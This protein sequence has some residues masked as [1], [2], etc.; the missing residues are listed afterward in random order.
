MSL[1]FRPILRPGVNDTSFRR[2]VR[3]KSEDCLTGNT[4]QPVLIPMSPRVFSLNVS[5]TANCG[6]IVGGESQV[7]ECCCKVNNI[8][9]GG[10]RN[11]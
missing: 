5:A 9:N 10:V 7:P 4:Y 3:S 2:E 8:V 11:S 1:T 6:S